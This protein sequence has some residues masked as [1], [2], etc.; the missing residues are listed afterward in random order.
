MAW[1]GAWLTQVVLMGLS[2]WLL[3][4][5]SLLAGCNQGATIQ[6][7]RLFQGVA[8][9]VGMW[10]ALALG[11]GLWAGVVS[12]GTLLLRDL[13][14][15]LL[16]YRA[17]FKPFFRP[18][19]SIRMSWRSEIWPMQWRL[20]VSGLFGYFACSL[21]NPVMFRHHGAMVAGQMGMTW[22]LINALQAV[23]GAWIQTKVP[24]FGMLIAQKDD[25]TL[26]RF[27][28]KTTRLSMSVMVTGASL[29]W[30]G[31]TAL[32][33]L[34][35]PLADRVLHPL[36]LGLFLIA[37]VVLQVSLC[38]TIY[39]RAHRQEPILGMSVVMGSSI[40]FSVWLLG[41]RFGPVG[42]ATGYLAVVVGCTLWETRIW[43]R[44]RAEWHGIPQARGTSPD[45][46]APFR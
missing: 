9:S 38:E 34:D 17:F 18:P 36:P 14:L 37:A 33:L 10:I 27:F 46:P 15:V 28:L 29:V 13:V 30:L 6:Q 1:K 2:L 31:V 40:G 39:L 23:A 5:T 16:R 12:A 45:P 42:A 25:E 41:S 8:A 11:A 35:H 32:R 21:F 19:E 7:F 4:I 43:F 44:C 3:P 20:A 24:R 26:D 22:A